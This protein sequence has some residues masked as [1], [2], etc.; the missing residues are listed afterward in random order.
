M[1]ATVSV[2]VQRGRAHT[3]TFVYLVRNQG[4]LPIGGFQIN[5][6]AANLFHIHGPAGWN[7]FGAGVCKGNYPGVL[8]YW[9][10]G[11][12]G[13]PSKQSQRFTFSVNTGGVMSRQYSLSQGQSVL[14]AHALG[15]QPSTLPA[16]GACSGHGGH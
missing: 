6:Q 15:P 5:G 3:Y 7:A 11:V 8:I 9:S 12:G 13:I 4:H 1:R 14:F 10:T 16:S 2:A